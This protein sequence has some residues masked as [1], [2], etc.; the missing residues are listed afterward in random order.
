MYIMDYANNRVQKWYPGGAY[1]TT[2]LS[3]S[4]SNPYGMQFDRYNNL[5]I[6][7]T[8][9]HRIVSSGILCRKF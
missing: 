5:V 4:V 3:S 8:N 1:G 7:D 6:A 9:N 2:V